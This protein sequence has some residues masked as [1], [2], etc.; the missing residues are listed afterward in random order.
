[1]GDLTWR[2]CRVDLSAASNRDVSG[3]E[4]VY[5]SGAVRVSQKRFQL[6]FEDENRK[7]GP[8][9]FSVRTGRWRAWLR[10]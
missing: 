8:I 10:D 1:M 6:N 2:D 7:S 3:D 4:E 5:A 9:P